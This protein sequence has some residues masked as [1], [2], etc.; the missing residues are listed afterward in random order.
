MRGL[1]KDVK[2]NIKDAQTSGM[3]TTN[4][5]GANILQAHQVAEGEINLASQTVPVQ[6]STPVLTPQ[7]IIP[8]E[9]PAPLDVAANSGIKLIA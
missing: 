2:I 5:V 1:S 7:S 4:A 6:R 9:N 8:I 3:R